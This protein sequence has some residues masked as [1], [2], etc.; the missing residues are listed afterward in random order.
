MNAE[1]KVVKEVIQ[2]SGSVKEKHYLYNMI[3][4]FKNV[5]I[6]F[7]LIFLFHFFFLF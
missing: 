7:I 6:G 4:V 3:F 5:K 2:M 1:T